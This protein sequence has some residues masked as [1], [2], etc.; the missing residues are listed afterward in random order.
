MEDCVV[1]FYDLNGHLILAKPFDFATD[2]ATDNWTPGLY[3]WEIWNG[4]QRQA[5]GKWVKE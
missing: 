5:S 1:R 3:L 4:T 2:V